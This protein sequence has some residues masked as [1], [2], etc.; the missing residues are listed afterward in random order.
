MTEQPTVAAAPPPLPTFDTPF[1]LGARRAA[2][3][4]RRAQPVFVLDDA[5]TITAPK[6]LPIPALEPLL[7]IGLDIPLLINA[8]TTAQKEG[9][10][11]AAGQMLVNFFIGH[12]NLPRQ[13]LDG[14][15]QVLR[16]LFG[17]DGYAALVAFAPEVEDMADI[18]TSLL[19]HYGTSLGELFGSSGSSMSTGEPPTPTSAATTALTSAQPSTETPEALDGRPSAA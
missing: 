7:G 2:R 17:D 1:N 4:A 19:R 8:V 5:T 16:N 13:V 12:E 11:E 3:H 6:G 9:G 10:A 18:A 14:V 15:T